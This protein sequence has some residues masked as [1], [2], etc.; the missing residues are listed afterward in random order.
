MGIT[1]RISDTHSNCMCASLKYVRPQIQKLDNL[2]RNTLHP[3][4][5]IEA[6]IQ[7]VRQEIPLTLQHTCSNVTRQHE[8]ITYHPKHFISFYGTES[9]QHWP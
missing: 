8:K 1:Y 9:V 6:R 7:K 4:N 3:N 2:T 5:T